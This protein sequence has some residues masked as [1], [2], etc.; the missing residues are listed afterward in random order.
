[1][2]AGRGLTRAE[3]WGAAPRGRPGGG[4]LEVS[5]PGL[6]GRHGQDGEAL[7]QP[8]AA[9]SGPQPGRHPA[10]ASPPFSLRLL[11]TLVGGGDELRTQ[12]GHLRSI[13]PDL[14]WSRRLPAH[15]TAPR[16]GPELEKVVPAAGG[17]EMRRPCHQRG[18]PLA[19]G[20]IRE[21]LARCSVGR[22]CSSISPVRPGHH[23][24]PHLGVLSWPLRNKDRRQPAAE[25]ARALGEGLALPV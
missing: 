17:L 16:W 6:Q 21:G 11:L 14:C 7:P 3:R 13:C 4:G 22:G 1:M 18:G 20:R 24:H 9:P 15:R 19:F 8:S 10:T 5:G 25:A 12:E 2:P 23:G